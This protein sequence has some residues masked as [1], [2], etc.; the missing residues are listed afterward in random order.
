M[1]ILVLMRAIT[2]ATF[3]MLLMNWLPLMKKSGDC[4]MNSNKQDQSVIFRYGYDTLLTILM[5]VGVGLLGSVILMVLVLLL[6][7]SAYASGEEQY[8]GY[9]VRKSDTSQGSLLFKTEQPGIYLSAPAVKT[10]VR[11]KVSGMLARAKV[12]QTFR[13]PTRHWLEGLYVFP[14]PSESAVDTLRMQVGERVIEGVIKEREEA[15]RT[16]VRAKHEGRKATLIEQERSNLFSNSVA[17]IGPGEEIK[18]EIEY[19]H[20]VNYQDGKFSLRFPMV[21]APRYIPGKPVSRQTDGGG[22]AFDTT[23]VKDASRIT[24]PVSSTDYVPGNPITM[25]ISLDAGITLASVDSSYHEVNVSQSSGKYHITFNNREYA[26]RDFELVWTP[27]IR[28]QPQAALFTQR[29][30]GEDYALLM[31]M[32]PNRDSGYTAHMPREVTYIIDTSGSMAGSSI[33]QAKSALHLALQRLRDNDRFN[34]I[35]F[36]TETRSLY[37]R[38]MPVTAAALAEARA[39]VHRLNAGGGTE[40]RPALEAALR[41]SNQRGLQRL[42]QVIFITDGSVGNEAELFGY[43]KDNIHDQR[44]F[45]IGIGSAPNSHFMKRAASFGRGSYTYIGKVSEVS[46]K[47]ASLF[48]RIDNPVLTDIHIDWKSRSVVQWPRRVTDLYQGDPIIVTAK[49]STLDKYIVVNGNH[50][51]KPWQASVPTS[52]SDSSDGISKLWARNHISVLMDR[53]YQGDDRNKIKNEVINVALQHH[54]VSKFTSLVAVDVTPT[55]PLDESVHK[56]SVLVN[57]PDGWKHEAVLAGLPATATP[58][59]ELVLWG[60]LSVLLALSISLY[61]YLGLKKVI[62]HEKK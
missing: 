45:T 28:N 38:P 51:G 27:D 20:V 49:L 1:M 46:D 8:T 60:L 10:D 43:I 54:L 50:A 25:N 12:T 31:V 13:N 22:W 9:F 36:N 4:V 35:E 61:L 5:S 55:R 14:L 53:L 23:L 32:P 11:I 39:Y 34:I 16:Y 7:P 29:L 26:K 2:H 47:M 42:R 37:H 41:P 21:V 33:R 19:Q 62:P 57:L 52:I 30:R 18:V 6:T 56:R 15:K 48:K 58:A 44:L 40:I 17:N 3:V 24:P 59:R